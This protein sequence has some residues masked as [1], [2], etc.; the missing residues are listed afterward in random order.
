MKPSILILF[1]LFAFF[2][3]CSQS[4]ETTETSA[5]SLYFPPIDSAA[6]ETLSP[7]AL[8]WNTEFL[9]ELKTYLAEKN[10]DAFIILKNGRIIVEYYFNDF[11]SN[12]PHAW[13]SAGKTLVAFSTGIAQQDGYLTLDDSTSEYLGPG[14]TTMTT[15][16]EGE[17]TIWNQLTM[18]AGGDYNVPDTACTDPACL[19][20]LNDPGTFWFYHNAF[21]TLLQPVLDSAIPMGFDSYFEEKLKSPTGISGTWLQFGYNRVFFSNARSMARF[22][23]LNLN[24]G[25]WDGTQLLNETY[26]DQMTN[27]SQNLNK[28]YGYLWWLNGKESYRLPQTTHE[29]QGKLIPNAPND[30]IAGLGKDDQKLYIVPSQDLIVIRMGGNAGNPHPGPSGFDDELWGKLSVLFNY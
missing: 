19:Q 6:W 24:R 15:Q 9:P 30:L 21:Y 27:T 14:W 8:N 3:G 18:T 13:N 12:T 26:F 4:D 29:F 2:S 7:E 16:Q 5:T 20:Y 23:I 25:N 10:T 11:T 17:I 22:G 1:I 28:A